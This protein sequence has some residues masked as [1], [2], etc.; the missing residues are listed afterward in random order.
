[1]SNRNRSPLDEGELVDGGG[2][3]MDGRNKDEFSLDNFL[4]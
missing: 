3:S 2:Q 4:M 1:M